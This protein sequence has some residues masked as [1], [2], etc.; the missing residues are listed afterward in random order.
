[1]KSIFTKK[2]KNKGF[3]ILEMIVVISIFLTLTGILIFNYDLF[4]KNTDF[5]LFV[6]E[7]AMRVKEV[8][9]NSMSGCHAY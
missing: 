4:Q 8:Q 1:M 2:I 3:T 7:V 9:H 5:G 6:Q